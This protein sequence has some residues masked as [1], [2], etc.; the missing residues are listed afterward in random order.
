MEELGAGFLR[1]TFAAVL[2]ICIWSKSLY[3]LD[4]LPAK[5]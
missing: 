3:S 4:G 2:S 1:L 5:M